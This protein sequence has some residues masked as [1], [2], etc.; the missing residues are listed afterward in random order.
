MQALDALQEWARLEN[1]SAQGVVT[2]KHRQSTEPEQPPDNRTIQMKM[3]I[4]SWQPGPNRII[5]LPT[6]VRR[7]A[8]CLLFD[9]NAGQIRHLTT[10]HSSDA[11]QPLLP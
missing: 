1:P 9:R 11:L 2:N 5:Q 6:E 4:V 8:H 7:K 10:V 3:A